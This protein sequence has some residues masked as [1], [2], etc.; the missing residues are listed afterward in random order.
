MKRLNQKTIK[1]KDMGQISKTLVLYALFFLTAVLHAQ[2]AANELISINVFEQKIKQSPNPQILDVRSQEEYLENHLKG[3]I[4]VDIKDD[5]AFGKIVETLDKKKPVFVYSINNGRSRK[6]AE[7]LRGQNFNEVYELPGGIARWIGAGKHVE[8]TLG[9][10]ISASEFQKQIASKNVVLVEVGSKYCGGCKKLKPI[11][12]EVVEE[13][14][15]NLIDVELYNNRALA[16]SL[17]IQSV[18]T[19]ILY[20]NNKVVW[21]KSGSISKADIINALDNSKKL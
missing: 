21:T 11:V 13:A 1:I 10:G 2:S 3:A 16:E 20:K 5:N 18:P 6:V 14:K 4:N 7:T 15:I 12:S 8:T 19:L 9:A 17:K